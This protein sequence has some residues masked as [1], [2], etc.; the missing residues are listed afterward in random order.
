[1]KIGIILFDINN[2]GGIIQHTEQLALGF[3]ELGHEVELISLEWTERTPGDRKKQGIEPSVFGIDYHPYGGWDL[4]AEMRVP[5]KGAKLAEAKERLSQLD[6]AVWTIPCPRKRKDSK[7]N[8][9]WLELYEAV[10][11]NVGII[12]DGNLIGF[13]PNL[14]EVLPHFNG[15]ACVHPCALNTAEALGGNTRLI[16]NPMPDW[17]GFPIT[18]RADGWLS[19]QTFK[20]WK[21][22]DM[23]VAAARYMSP[24]L[25]K[26]MAGGGIEQCYMTSK[27]KCKENYFHHDGERI[28]DAAVANGMD[29]RGFIS[30]AERDM[31]MSKV[32]AF[33]DPS[34]SRRYVKT[35]SHFNRVIIEA[36]RMGCIP[37]AQKGMTNHEG[38]LQ[39]GVHYV[40]LDANL[41]HQEYAEVVED[42]S[43]SDAT[44]YYDAWRQLLGRFDRRM[45]AQ[46]Y[47]DL[48]RRPKGR[49][50]PS[51]DIRARS[52]KIM[53]HFS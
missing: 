23:L 44:P 9:D 30:G 51:V 38:W 6:G 11:V 46:Q 31:W 49:F 12:H 3:R 17:D 14:V 40:G 24:D 35:G 15:F 47:F 37:V 10:P 36:M 29:F 2:P 53:K 50:N 27:D 16:P 7:G 8:S 43:R 1:M 42:A 28:W 5:Y 21:R 4:T 19:A 32:R 39:D 45:V 18:P 20:G 33:V 13:Y 34:L 22:V 25:I 26:T 41:T 48:A 52:A